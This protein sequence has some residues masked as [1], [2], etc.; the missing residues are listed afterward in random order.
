MVPLSNPP[1]SVFFFSIQNVVHYIRLPR[2]QFRIVTIARGVK[3]PPCHKMP[4]GLLKIHCIIIRPFRGA[5]RPIVEFR[6]C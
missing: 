5:L 3:F 2:P 1:Y 4:L 6:H